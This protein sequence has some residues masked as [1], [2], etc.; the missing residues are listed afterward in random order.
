LAIFDFL[1]DTVAGE[2]DRLKLQARALVRLAVRKAI[3]VGAA[4]VL[5]LAGLVF[6]MLGAYH[7]LDEEYASWQAG[8]LV[9]L[10]AVAVSLLLL[11]L[12]RLGGGGRSYRQD[13]REARLREELAASRRE[14]LQ[15][16]VDLGTAASAAAGTVARDF[17]KSHRPSTFNMA[18]S[19][20]V[21]GL[22]A[23]RAAGRGSRPAPRPPPPPRRRGFRRRAREVE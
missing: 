17:L 14:E 12:A 15:A 4:I 8:G 18:L 6:V 5:L 11:A 13:R 7:S 20:F 1:R 3:F 23:S 16:A 21:A 10:G 19:A 2:A 9:A 22:V